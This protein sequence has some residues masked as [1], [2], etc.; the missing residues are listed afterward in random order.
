VIEEPLKFELPNC[1]IAKAN[2]NMGVVLPFG[3]ITTFQLPMS[4]TLVGVLLL[5]PQ[6]VTV[7]S[8]TST[9]K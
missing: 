8:R 9:R 2:T 4:P 7:A 6:P 5:L 1:D 3:Y